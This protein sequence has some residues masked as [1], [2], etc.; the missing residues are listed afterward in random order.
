MR[1]G[2]DFLNVDSFLIYAQS[3]Q[4]TNIST[5]TVW[6]DTANNNCIY[7]Y[8]NSTW[9][10]IT[11]NNRFASL[12]AAFNEL[13][14]KS[15]IQAV[16]IIIESD[17]KEYAE[18]SGVL[19]G[20]GWI[21]I[22]TAE[23]HYLYGYLT[24]TSC[25]LPIFYGHNSYNSAQE[26]YVSD[27]LRIVCRNWTI[28]LTIDDC[29]YFRLQTGY[30]YGAGGLNGSQNTVGIYITEG[31]N[32]AITNTYI[33]NAKHLIYVANM[34][35]LYCKNITGN[36]C[37]NF[38]SA[39]T[40]TIIWDGTR[41][42]GSL[43]QY[44]T[45]VLAP[46]ASAI[47]NLTSSSGTTDAPPSPTNTTITTLTPQIIATYGYKENSSGG[48]TT[49]RLAQGIYGEYTNVGLIWW[50]ADLFGKTID[51][52]TMTLTR[53]SSNNGGVNAVEVHLYVVTCEQPSGVHPENHIVNVNGITT[54]LHG[55]VARGET[56]T[57]AN[58]NLIKLLQN[59]A[60]NNV[61]STNT[62]RAL[63]LKTT[64][65]EKIQNQNYSGNYAVFKTDIQLNISYH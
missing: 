8:K 52:A 11:L 39:G 28:P 48:W 33:E 2:V 3:S 40:S 29:S 19:G 65:I 43:N 50:P 46:D 41:P 31:S 37:I 10:M 26:M 27:A 24:F 38:L 54:T 5:H 17:L 61:D 57:I 22:Y 16:S 51:S 42:E 53:D 64:D 62:P 59:I 1:S 12:Q 55:T 49:N 9:N 58:A 15:I 44:A 6:I 4:P 25:H 35:T 36:T 20:G 30:I 60:T 13:S 56:L 34:S 45:N 18:L 21:N 32:I 47:L 7:R 14:K 63:M 23:T